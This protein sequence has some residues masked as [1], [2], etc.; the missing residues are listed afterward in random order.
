MR[1]LGIRAK[2]EA[3]ANELL[4]PKNRFDGGQQIGLGTWFVNVAERTQAAGFSYHVGGGLLTE[5]QNF[6]SRSK[7]TH[8]PSH[9]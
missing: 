4:S 6:R 7:L 3:I 8:S 9:L 2:L 1:R 5:E